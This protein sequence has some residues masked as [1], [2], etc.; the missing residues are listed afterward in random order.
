MWSRL[1]LD[2]NCKLLPELRS[3]PQSSALFSTTVSYYFSLASVSSLSSPFALPPPSSLCL[4]QFGIELQGEG[5]SYSHPKLTSEG[6][7]RSRKRE[8]KMTTIHLPSYSPR[9]TPQL[10]MDF[11]AFNWPWFAVIFGAALLG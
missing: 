4:Y 9:T 11:Y 10:L 3:K 5:P 8:R 1:N 6:G 2:L 7:G